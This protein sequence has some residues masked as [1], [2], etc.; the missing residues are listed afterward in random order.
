MA[1][2]HIIDD[3]VTVLASLVDLLSA[4]G[5]SVVTNNTLE[6]GLAAIREQ[7][8]D[9]LILE[10]R[11]GQGAGWQ[12]LEQLSQFVAVMVLSGAALED[13]V[14]RG[15]ESGAVEYLAKPYR[16]A[17]LVAR[18]RM[19]VAASVERAML[20]QAFGETV[21]PEDYDL[22]PDTIAPQR[23]SA[24]PRPSAPPTFSA[25][26]QSL[27]DM[28]DMSSLPAFD[29]TPYMPTP[30]QAPVAAR[31]QRRNAP[32]D[33][34][35]FMS[36]AEE[37]AMLRNSAGTPLNAEVIVSPSATFGE[38]LRAERLRRH[39]SL[40]QLENELK[41]R[42]TYLQA[43]EDEKLTLLPRGP[44]ALQMLRSYGSYFGVDSSEIEA[45]YRSNFSIELQALSA[46]LGYR[47][48]KPLPMRLILFVFILLLLVGA[49]A[50]LFYLDPPFLQAWLGAE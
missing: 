31:R 18:V 9:L 16:S 45:Y 47:P 8:P 15:F 30:T 3:D 22:P 13:D 7:R 35:V 2:I 33:D 1:L 34:T 11:T 39:M 10:V 17:E 12:A 28:P 37:M 29:P 41:I 44:A 49:A 27:T 46:P 40:V 14:V 23:P 50:T 38:R 24:L 20:E 4:E 5:F 6:S 19:R 32:A 43:V 25:V 26:P 42:M 21:A 36:D 48:T